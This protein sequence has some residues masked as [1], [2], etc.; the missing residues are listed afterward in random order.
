[1]TVTF[2]GRTY[3]EQTWWGYEIADMVKDAQGQLTLSSP[4]S[5]DLYGMT[6][7]DELV[8]P[9]EQLLKLMADTTPIEDG[10]GYLDVLLGYTDGL[11]GG[12]DTYWGAVVYCD[13]PLGIPT[14]YVGLWNQ[15]GGFWEPGTGM[16]Y[17][18][19]L[20]RINKLT[21]RR[22]GADIYCDY[23]LLFDDGTTQAGT[24]TWSV[25]LLPGDDL[26]PFFGAEFST[27]ADV[28]SVV[29]NNVRQGS[30]LNGGHWQRRMLGR[31]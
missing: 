23:N 26:R 17:E 19:T 6:L 13:A 18:A 15:V 8:R 14:V 22:V 29:F 12:P 5:V 20:T 31:L 24:I 7:V 28:L 16:S 21:V 27:D 3:E 4:V 1:M 30:G 9:Q 10:I 25:A 2:R 11:V